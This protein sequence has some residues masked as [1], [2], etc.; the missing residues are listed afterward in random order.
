MAKKRINNWEV[1]EVS[2]RPD[3]SMEESYG[4]LEILV[5]DNTYTFDEIAFSADEDEIEMDNIVD[6]FQEEMEEVDF[7]TFT[8]EIFQEIT[9]VC[10]KDFK[11]W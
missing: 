9:G 2:F 3:K 10:T 1:L 6:A 7:G 11:S 5:N 8:E 4:Y